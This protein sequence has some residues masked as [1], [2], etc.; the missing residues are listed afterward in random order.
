MF[1][2][3]RKR[4]I[5]LLG[6]PPAPWAAGRT[7]G[8]LAVGRYVSEAWFGRKLARHPPA[9]RRV[10]NVPVRPL[11]GPSPLL[12]HGPPEPV[13]QARPGRPGWR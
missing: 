1:D 10:R 9:N 8:V 7:L 5:G 6:A 11:A 2:S 3:P 13:R 12:R 4:T